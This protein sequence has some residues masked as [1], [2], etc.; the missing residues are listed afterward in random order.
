VKTPNF[1]QTRKKNLKE[2][3]TPTA[4]N[5]SGIS[6]SANTNPLDSQIGGAHYKQYKIQPVEYAMANSL[7]YCQA[8][9]IKYVTRYRDKNGKEDLLKAIHNIEILIALEYAP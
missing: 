5:E 3:S 2:I 7:N 6:T 8:N 1:S 4:L 9:A